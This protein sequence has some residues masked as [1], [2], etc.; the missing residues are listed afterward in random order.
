MHATPFNICTDIPSG[1]FDLVVCSEG[2][3]TI[4]LQSKIGRQGIQLDP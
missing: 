1:P 3:K 2:K 4:L